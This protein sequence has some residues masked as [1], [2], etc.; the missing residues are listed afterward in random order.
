M[1]GILVVF[2]NFVAVISVASDASSS[3][4]AYRD[5]TRRVT[6]RRFSVRT[7]KQSTT[8]H[9]KI[10]I[11]AIND[12]FMLLAMHNFSSYGKYAVTLASRIILHVFAHIL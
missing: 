5:P 11:D 1:L 9:S 2:T 7:R 4:D 6:D 3:A 8:K 12:N 10:S